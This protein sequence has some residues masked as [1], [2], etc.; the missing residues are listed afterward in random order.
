M[1]HLTAIMIMMSSCH[2]WAVPV[3]PSPSYWQLARALRTRPEQGSMD[4]GNSNLQGTSD[5][6]TLSS[7]LL[8]GPGPA[9]ATS[10]GDV[11]LDTQPPRP[12]SKQRCLCL[13]CCSCWALYI[14]SAV[15]ITVLTYAGTGMWSGDG[16]PTTMSLVHLGP[17]DPLAVCNDGSEAVYY[18]NKATDPA[19]SH[20]WMMWL[21]GGD[22]C[23]TESMCNQRMEDQPWLMSS[24]GYAETSEAGVGV[25]NKN[26]PTF[27]GC[28]LAFVPYCTSDLHLGDRNASAETWG[29]HFRGQRVARSVVK[30]LVAAG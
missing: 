20:L 6:E 5:P 19:K 9:G 2:P 21:Q 17:I 28:N 14:V 29:W 26:D 3:A 13:S 22:L 27:G 18:F 15:W 10:G 1:R 11:A 16:D 25:M 7:A 30:G 8:D 23:E 24:N 12:L 4:G